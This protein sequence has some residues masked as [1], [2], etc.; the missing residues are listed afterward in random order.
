SGRAATRPEASVSYIFVIQEGARRADEGAGEA[1]LFN[2]AHTGFD[3]AGV[4]STMLRVLWA[5]CYR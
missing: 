1:G 4:I 3:S 5:R 2:N